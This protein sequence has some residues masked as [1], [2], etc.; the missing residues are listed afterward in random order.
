M[1]YIPNF[2]YIV[3]VLKFR[4]FRI[5]CK[6]CK[7][8]KEFQECMESHKWAIFKEFQMEYKECLG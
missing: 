6:I 5:I 2:D 4:L 1:S 7:R 3:K 8:C